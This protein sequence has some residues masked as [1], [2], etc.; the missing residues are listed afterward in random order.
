MPK[1][2]HCFPSAQT[3]GIS[4]VRGSFVA[5]AAIPQMNPEKKSEA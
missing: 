1:A 3:T 4:K 5:K 2:F